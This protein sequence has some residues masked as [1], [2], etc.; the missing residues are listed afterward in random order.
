MSTDRLDDDA[1]ARR[2]AVDRAL[3]ALRP[4]FRMPP[5]RE[6]RLYHLIG[7]SKSQRLTRKED[8]ELRDLLDEADQRSLELLR[9][10]AAAAAAAQT[11]GGNGRK[12][13]GRPGKRTAAGSRRPAVRA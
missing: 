10:A 7:K 12:P 13:T 6:Q 9:A 1:T 2:K 4:S 8:K 3:K 11:P 5:A